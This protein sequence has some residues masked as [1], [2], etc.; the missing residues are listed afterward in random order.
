MGDRANVIVKS[1]EEEVVLYTHWSGSELPEIVRLGMVRGKQRWDDFQYLTRILFCELIPMKEWE[2]LSGF[3]ITTRV[4]DGGRQLVKVDCDA[5]TVTVGNKD[6]VS[7]A[8]FAEL[9][10]AEW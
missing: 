7:F 4:H 3:G 1:G 10:T 6:A 8:A 9:T 5:Q 2:E